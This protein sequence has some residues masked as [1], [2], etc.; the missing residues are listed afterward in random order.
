MYEKFLSLWIYWEQI[1]LAIFLV[2]LIIILYFNRSFF[3]DSIRELKHVV[4]P[5]REE[6]KKYFIIV[7][8]VLVLFGIYL[9]IFGTLF[10]EWLFFLKDLVWK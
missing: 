1:V 8:T 6:T 7:L 10:S 4:W 2:L 3:K 9:F 5:T